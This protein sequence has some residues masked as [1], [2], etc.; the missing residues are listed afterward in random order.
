LYHSTKENGQW[1]KPKIFK[2][3]L[4][5][6]KH[7]VGLR[8]NASGQVLYYFRGNNLFQGAIFS[9][10]LKKTSRFK[11]IHVPT[12]FDPVSAHTPPHFVSDTV[13]IF[14]SNAFGGLGGLDLFK[15]IKR[16]GAWTTPENLG[17]SINSAYDENFPFLAPD[18][19]TLYF[20]S[21]NPDKSIGGYDIFKATLTRSNTMESLGLPVNSTADDTHFSTGN[22][23]ITAYFSS[24]RK[25]GYGAR[26]LYTAYFFSP[27]AGLPSRPFSPGMTSK[28]DFQPNYLEFKPILLNGT[29]HPLE[30]EYKSYFNNLI[31]ILKEN[32][33][34]KLLISGYPHRDLSLDEGIRQSL[35]L[36]T[37]IHQFFSKV[38]LNTQQTTYYVH[39][40]PLF[41]K[42][43]QG[44]S[45]R[46]SGD[47][48]M[49]MALPTTPLFEGENENW[50]K[51]AIDFK[52][53]LKEMTFAELHKSDLEIYKKNEKLTFEVIP[54]QNKILIYSG[55]FS[56][57]S[58]AQW[59][60][61]QKYKIVAFLDGVKLSAEMAKELVSTYP[62]LSEYIHQ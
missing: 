10:T 24:N 7:E 40:S 31:P 4:N 54:D 59:S 61:N 39:Y 56:S 62:S 51:D 15:S 45:F 55:L 19:I 5:S 32:P 16:N 27:L 17:S 58:L 43:N 6:S 52:W 12:P 33:T 11:L 13:V 57:F 38:V 35:N 29:E 53:L 8:F 36:L 20:S 41:E 22:D 28:D 47:L 49:N 44:I 46:F 21:N 30:G 3:V 25:S 1:Q 34:L 42:S 23:G 60:N 18:G 9:D 48:P 50:S 26:D 37:D 14:A 2:P